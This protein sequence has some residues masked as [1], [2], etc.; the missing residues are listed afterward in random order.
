MAAGGDLEQ[1]TL[2]PT[3]SGTPQGGILSPVLA[4]LA[5]DGLERCFQT[6][7][8]K[9]A[10]AARPKSIWSA[11]RM[12]SL[13]LAAPRP[14]WTTAVR[15]L[16]EQLLRERGLALS[17]E[18]TTITHIA[19]GCDFLGSHHAQVSGVS[20]PHPGQTAR[21]AVPHEGPATHA[22]PHCDARR[23]PHLPAQPDPAR[24]GV[25]L[26]SRQEWANLP[27]GSSARSSTRSAT[28]PHADIATKAPAGLPPAIFGRTKDASQCFQVRWRG[29][30][31]PCFTPH[32]CGASG[33]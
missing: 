3:D 7:F 11:M 17:P 9:T 5:L 21:P 20:A 24:M 26:S 16:V 4:N 13:S 31:T 30:D 29:N 2:H 1:H 25:V 27:H 12:T 23:R 18:Q 22:A 28:G 32:R 10:E 15:P 8:P 33:M 6:A 14:C 19:D